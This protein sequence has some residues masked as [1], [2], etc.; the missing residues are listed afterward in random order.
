MERVGRGMINLKP[1]L[2]E[3]LIIFDFLIHIQ[4]I[5]LGHTVAILL[6]LPLIDF[7]TFQPIIHHGW[8]QKHRH[9]NKMQVAALQSKGETKSAYTLPVKKQNLTIRHI[10]NFGSGR[11]L[12]L[13]RIRQVV[14][15]FP[16]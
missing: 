13:A 15:N 1:K 9:Y 11:L 3:S 10:M 7:S 12:G 8:L 6:H 14:Q 2:C 5:Q 16:S 4:L